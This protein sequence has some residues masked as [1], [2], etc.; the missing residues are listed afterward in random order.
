MEKKWGERCRRVQY[1]LFLKYESVL[2]EGIVKEADK[3]A[4]LVLFL[5]LQFHSTVR[6]HVGHR[7]QRG[8]KAR[9]PI[10]IFSNGSN[11]LEDTTVSALKVRMQE[12]HFKAV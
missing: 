5:L 7:S 8:I 9:R 4:C 3:L 12:Q 11:A 1:S 2:A 6:T 10:R